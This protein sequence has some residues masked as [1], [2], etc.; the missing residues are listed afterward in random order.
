MDRLKRYATKA[1]LCRCFSISQPTVAKRV[2]GIEEEIKRGR[3]NRYAIA[4]GL[5]SIA[6]FADYSKY[7]KRLNDKNLRRTVKPFCLR[8]ALE[9]LEVDGGDGGA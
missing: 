2:K 8:E 9:Y 4:D 3:Y 6:V 5:I 7:H 1:E